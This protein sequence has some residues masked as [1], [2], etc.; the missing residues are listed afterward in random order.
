[1]LAI[2]TKQATKARQRLTFFPVSKARITKCYLSRSCM[3]ICLLSLQRKVRLRLY[4]Y[5]FLQML[6][7]NKVPEKLYHGQ[8]QYITNNYT[9]NAI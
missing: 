1:V 8:L 6:N 5:R 7:M 2:A 3:Y 9:V 4:Y